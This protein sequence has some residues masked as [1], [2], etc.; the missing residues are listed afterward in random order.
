MNTRMGILSIVIMCTVMISGCGD[1]SGPTSSNPTSGFST[2]PSGSMGLALSSVNGPG[3][4][5]SVGQIL[6]NPGGF[7]GQ[8]VQLEGRAIEEIDG[9]RFLFTDGTGEIRLQFEPAGP[10]PPVE[11]AI[12]VVGTASEGTGGIVVKIDVSSFETLPPLGCEDILDVRAR[13][14]DPGYAFGNVVG[15]YLAFRGVPPGEKLLRM[16]WGDGDVEETSVGAGE[17]RGDGLFDLEGVVAHE[18]PDVGREETKSVRATLFIA[19][20]EGQCGRV[21]EV[22]VTPGEGPGFAGGGTI[23]LSV[24]EGDT[25]GSAARFSVRGKV[26]NKST[27]TVNVS[28]VFQT[29]ER[30]TLIP[31]SVNRCTV[32]NEELVECEIEG[33]E[34]GEKLTRVVQYQ[35]P[36]VSQSVQIP[37]HVALVS[38]GFRPVATYIL[39][40]EP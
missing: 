19:G 6:D 39:T 30:C 2:T 16:D 35:A 9:V 28:M 21:R 32:L 18:Y 36:T 31:E 5:T 7:I 13:F 24:D 29:P 40:V 12:R 22:T 8:Q 33:L 14:T 11:V 15:Y 25:I 37:V 4:V 10:F 17:P 20:R 1:D 23:S 3:Q 38:G 27:S 26:D 34:P